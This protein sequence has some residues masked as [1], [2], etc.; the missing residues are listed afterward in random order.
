MWNED[1]MD[2]HVCLFAPWLYEMVS[3][4]LGPEQTYHGRMMHSAETVHTYSA[5]SNAF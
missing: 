5:V 3:P 1:G 2:E 4:I